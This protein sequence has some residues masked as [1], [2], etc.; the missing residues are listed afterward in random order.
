MPINKRC[1]AGL[2][3]E[4]LRLKFLRAKYDRRRC[5]FC[6]SVNVYY[7]DSDR[8]Q[9][10]CRD[11]WKTT[12]LTR[13]TA[14]D[15]TRRSLRFWY[16]VIW[17]FV[18]RHPANKAHQL[19]G[20]NEPMDVWRGYQRLRE[21]LKEHSERSWN[22]EEGTYE[23]DEALYGGRWEN[24]RKEI[25]KKLREEGKNKRGR[26]AKARKQPVFG[27]LKRNGKVYLKLIDSFDSGTLE[28]IIKD[29]VETNSTVLTDTWK[30]YNGLAGLGFIHRQI[31]H[32]EGEYAN[33]PIHINGMEGFWGLS[34]T[35]MHTY[36]GIQDHNWEYYLKE[37]EFRYNFRELDYEE[38][39][40][41]L[42]QIL[43]RCFKG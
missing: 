2:S 39:F 20:T 35:N 17:Q 36:K 18:L 40:E 24:L 26:G 31:E 14:L 30:G 15:G 19:L 38:Q 37:M 8:H 43:M 21:A 42:I 13:G 12:S 16:E 29:L 23:V 7:T 4:T 34:K 1:S 28:P 10:R 3:D 5:D 22:P 11:C 41:K 33:G 25:K 27:I 32:G 6:G 9:W